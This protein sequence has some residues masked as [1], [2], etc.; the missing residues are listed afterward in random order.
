MDLTFDFTMAF[1][2]IVNAATQQIFAHEALV[3]G[4]N[5]EPAGWVFKKINDRNCYHFEQSCKIKAI[6]LAAKLNMSSSLC[7]NFMPNAVHRPQL[8]IRSAID[9]ARQYGFPL[10]RIILEITECEKVDDYEH[11]REIIRYYKQLGFKTALDDFG[12]GYSGLNLFAE[13]Q[14]DIVKL[15]MALVRNIDRDKARQA[16]IKGIFQVCRDLST[17]VIAEGVETYEELSIL[18]SFGIE[19]FQGYYFAK[20]AFQ[21]LATLPSCMGTHPET[22]SSALSFETQHYA[23]SA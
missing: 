14:T 4:L 23:F 13:I 16:I 18:Q 1:Q 12:A 5:N 10:H 22:W 7:I 9:T 20:P 8:C 3:R 15:D 21:S 17:M 19:L 2:P 6:K 11:L